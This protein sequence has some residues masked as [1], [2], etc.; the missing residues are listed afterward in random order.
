MEFLSHSR[1]RTTFAALFALM[2]AMLPIAVAAQSTAPPRPQAPTAPVIQWANVK[3]A[4]E[5]PLGTR[6]YIKANLV[7]V[8]APR[9]E[10]RQ[11]WS[12]YV[13]D[14][15]G[16][17]R[18]VVFQDTWA[19]I[20]D[21]SFLEPGTRLDLYARVGEFRNERQL[22]IEQPNHFRRTPGTL[23]SGGAALRSDR[24]AGRSFSLFSIGSINITHVGQPVRIRGNVVRYTE[25]DNERIPFRVIVRDD[26]GE[27]EGLYWKAVAEKI[28]PENRPVVGQP[29]ELS[30]IVGEFDGKMQVRVDE[31]QF[32]SR[33]FQVNARSPKLT[34]ENATARAAGFGAP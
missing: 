11:P 30:G 9:P 34:D 10:S 27:V 28:A 22:E 4:L 31:P 15:T 24:D 29:I 33:T 12:L 21:T 18:C 20:P 25:S 26:T 13:S 7:S 19:K 2:I 8:G 1:T 16:T 32:V 6:L 17:I 23:S 14:S 3:T 5:A